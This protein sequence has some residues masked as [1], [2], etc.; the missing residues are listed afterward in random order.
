MLGGSEGCGPESV[1]VGS[2]GVVELELT[3]LGEFVSFG[4]ELVV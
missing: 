3:G 2:V 4:V 1:V